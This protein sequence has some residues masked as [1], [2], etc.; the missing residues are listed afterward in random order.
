MTA[1]GIPTGNERFQVSPEEVGVMMSFATRPDRF[2]KAIKAKLEAGVTSDELEEILAWVGLPKSTAARVIHSQASSD[3]VS[4]GGAAAGPRFRR[5]LGGILF[6]S[7]ALTA[8]F[9]VTSLEWPRVM[10][11]LI[12]L[13]L[14]TI[15]LY[16]LIGRIATN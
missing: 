12:A 3:G 15:G 10:Y 6:V 8:F 5:H 7:A 11:M 14:A 9:V 4:S 13:V 16:K 2:T 1:E